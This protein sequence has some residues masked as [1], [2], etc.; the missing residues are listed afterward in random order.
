MIGDISV[1]SREKNS[2]LQEHFFIS[3]YTGFLLSTCTGKRSICDYVYAEKIGLKRFGSW[4][5]EHP[6]KFYVCYTYFSAITMQLDEIQ[7]TGSIDNEKLN[8]KLSF[9]F[10]I[11]QFL[12]N[13]RKHVSI[14]D[15]GMLRQI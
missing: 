1:N 15:C 12:K 9:L 4:D 6:K 2:K 10:T 3:G 5:M 13:V 11:K 14:T 8:I 7:D